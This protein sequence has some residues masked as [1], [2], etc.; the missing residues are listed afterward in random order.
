MPFVTRLHWFLG[1]TIYEVEALSLK[2]QGVC[3][4]P[5]TISYHIMSQL[6][7]DILTASKD[8]ISLGAGDASRILFSVKS[9]GYI[10]AA[11][12]IALSYGVYC[13]VTVPRQ[14]RHFPCASFLK[15]LPSLIRK[16]A[17]DIIQRKFFLPKYKEHGLLVVSDQIFQLR[18]YFSRYKYRPCSL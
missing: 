17:P 11:V 7:F 10:T 8:I 16:E 13:R 12:V 14:Y 9:L 5:S 3:Q 6:I 18:C 1:R 4:S 15:I 2:S